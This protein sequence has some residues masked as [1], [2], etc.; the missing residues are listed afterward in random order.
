M[1]TRAASAVGRAL[2]SLNV[3]SAVQS[4]ADSPQRPEAW[5]LHLSPPPPSPSSAPAAAAPRFVHSLSLP[6]LQMER[7][8]RRIGTPSSSRPQ[9]RGAGLG[10]LW[11]AARTRPGVGVVEGLRRMR[12][13]SLRR[14]CGCPV[15]AATRAPLHLLL[16][17]TAPSWRLG[18]TA[19]GGGEK[20]W[21]RG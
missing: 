8:A 11:A 17:P 4:R 14:A 6:L 2:S 20:G 7:G 16:S 21:W 9:A 1:P 15:A 5:N 3:T 10:F 18:R 12:L 19:A 13:T